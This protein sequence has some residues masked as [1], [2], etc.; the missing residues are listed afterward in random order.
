M[1]D[2]KHYRRIRRTQFAL[3]LPTLILAASISALSSVATA[4]ASEACPNQTVREQQ[5][6]EYL[7]DCRGYEQVSPVQTNGAEVQNGQNHGVGPSFAASATGAAIVYKATGAF[8]GSPS[9]GTES[10][11]LG[12]SA[13][14]GLQWQTFSLNPPNRLGSLTVGRN[15]EDAGDFL[16]LAPDLACGVM[17]TVLPQ[18]TLPPGETAEESI[19]NLYAWSAA[20][21]SYALVTDARPEEAYAEPPVVD[22]ASTDCTHVIFESEAGFA[23]AS[24]G[25]TYL[26]EWDEGALRVASLLPDDTLP[27]DGVQSTEGGEAGSIVNEISSNG[28]HVFFTAETDKG[29]EWDQVFMRV[30][31]TETVEVSASETGGEETSNAV[32]EAASKGGQ[33]IFFLAEYGRAT[34]ATS[35]GETACEANIGRGCDLYEYDTATKSL[36]DISADSNP[37]DAEGADVDSVLGISEEG[38]VVYFSASGQLVSGEGNTQATNT[39][40]GETNVYAY[41]DGQLV[42]V[43][44]IGS[45]EALEHQGEDSI[46]RAGDGESFAVSRVSSDGEYLLFATDEPIKQSDGVTYDNDEASTGKPVVEDYEYA[47][48][49]SSVTCVSCDPSGAQP[50]LRETPTEAFGRF[51]QYER[52]ID[53]DALRNLT[54][55][56][57]VYFQTSNPVLSQAIDDTLNV[58]E[59]QPEGVGTCATGQPAGCISI[60][61]SGTNPDS[62]YFEGA[63]AD[64]ENVYLTTAAKLAPEDRGEQRVLYDVR[65]DGGFL[66]TGTEECIG[67]ECQGPLPAQEATPTP[68]STLSAENGNVDTVT[69]EAEAKKAKLTIVSKHSSGSTL[70]VKL[71]VSGAGKVTLAG[72][73]LRKLVK[74][75]KA[76]GKLTLTTKL[77]SAAVAKLAKGAE[78]R[79]KL[80]V[81][82]KPKGA[83]KIVKKITVKFKR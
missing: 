27:D 16:Y 78:V 44:S 5:H 36:T 73:K 18:T 17:R 26:Y 53:G 21:E 20:S 49:S 64:G 83:E 46:S 77:T 22:G 9:G 38:E 63:S 6:A 59:F 7:P 54:N 72:A 52:V 15:E 29:N 82:F 28:S 33:R 8:P 19:H 37:E 58:Y 10:Q 70:R 1:F 4:A 23:G 60:L 47:L 48:G 55:D 14:I 57:E 30:D 24:A 43:A 71:K 50:L 69:R 3:A 34:D 67:E 68:G 45:G 35:T 51:G 61:D 65:V 42:Y 62:T 76:E 13:A 2:S 80:S 41:R 66:Q 81:T 39:A 11:Y 12:T 74:R 31:G 40:E 56:G 25:P 75:A 32:F 79:T